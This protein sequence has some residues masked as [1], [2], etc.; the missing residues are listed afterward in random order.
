MSRKVLLRIA[1]FFTLF[2]FV[3]HTIGT[4]SAPPP[5]QADVVKVYETMYQTAVMMPMGATQTV[6][7]MMF[8]ANFCLSIY[9]LVAGLLLIIQ[10]MTKEKTTR[11]G[12]QVLVVNSV[13]LFATGVTSFFV[14]FP[15]PAICLS[16]AGILGLVASRKD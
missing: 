12:R 1:A 13:G 16:L 10:S 2:V 3:G 6:G 7:K 8:G 11:E 14:F 5:D 15:L 9:V 4:F